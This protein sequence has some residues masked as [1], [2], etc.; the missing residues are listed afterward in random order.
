MFLK[1]Q[2]AEHSSPVVGIFV[3]RQVMSTVVLCASACRGSLILTVQFLLISCW[4]WKFHHA[5]NFFYVKCILKDPLWE[6]VHFR[7]TS[8]KEWNNLIFIPLLWICGI[9][10]VTNFHMNILCSI[11]HIFFLLLLQNSYLIMFHTT[12]CG[13]RAHVFDP[14]WD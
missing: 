3:A 2:T 12:K 6:F 10:Q 9:N 1:T 8:P 7:S 4:K 13:L 5:W 11:F 14:N